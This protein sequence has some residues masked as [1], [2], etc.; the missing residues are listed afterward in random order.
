MACVVCRRSCF[1]SFSPLSGKCA[2]HFVK[3]SQLM[4]VSQTKHVAL[5]TSTFLHVAVIFYFV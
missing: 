1:P 5:G 4:R 2:S 3:N